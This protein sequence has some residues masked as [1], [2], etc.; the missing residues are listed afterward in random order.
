MKKPGVGFL[1]STRSISQLWMM[2]CV[3]LLTTKC[4]HAPKEEKEDS[5]PGLASVGTLDAPPAF[6]LFYIDASEAN[7]RS[8]IR[9]FLVQGTE[10]QINAD[11]EFL[12][13]FSNTSQPVVSRSA[14]D[15]GL[16]RSAIAQQFPSIPKPI[17]EA[18]RLLSY[19]NPDRL[20]WEQGEVD[21]HLFMS[22]SLH[23]L[24]KDVFLERLLDPFELYKDQTNLLIYTESKVPETRQ[25]SDSQLRS[26]TYK[27][28]THDLSL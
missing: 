10:K 18:D 15:L 7:N 26:I 12:A 23:D 4:I 20:P 28:L 1:A 17:E 6:A 5:A 11:L 16:I 9:S 14:D 25:F 13:F 19:L 22:S 3:A 8:N 2:V 27:Q 21:L 24:A